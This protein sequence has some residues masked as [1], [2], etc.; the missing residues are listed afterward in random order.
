M[1]TYDLMITITCAPN[2]Y[3][4][5]QEVCCI[6]TYANVGSGDITGAVVQTTIPSAI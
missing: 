3:T 1:A 5:G 4:A 6:V 2:P